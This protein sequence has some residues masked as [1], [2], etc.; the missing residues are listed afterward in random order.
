MHPT[1]KYRITDEQRTSVYEPADDTFLLLDALE[2]DI[3]ALRKLDPVVVIEIGSGSGVVSAFC[4]QLLR[5]PVINFATDMN[6][7][8]LKCT[9]NTAQLNNVLVE[10]VQC[11][12]MRAIDH[13]LRNQV[14][15]LL[16]NPPYVATEQEATSDAERCWAGGPTGHN[17]VDRV[18]AQLPEILSLGGFFYVV[19]LEAN[20]ISKM[21]NCMNSLNFSS[22]VLLNRRCGI[23]HLFVLKFTRCK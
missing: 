18:F 3:E 8:A 14:D 10:T 4:Q 15:V 5:Q 11:D 22:K 23:E 13:R 20:D 17:V 7:Y 19:A 2:E 9:Q 6:F 21:L 1:P 12:L 16:F